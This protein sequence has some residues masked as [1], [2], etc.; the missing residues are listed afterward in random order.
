MDWDEKLKRKINLSG[1][2]LKNMHYVH[3]LYYKA[4]RRITYLQEKIQVELKIVYRI[5]HPP[6]E[7][8]EKKFGSMFGKVFKNSVLF[9]ELK[10]FDLL[11][12]FINILTD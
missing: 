9:R 2:F 6:L 10:L 7:I 4:N 8:F 11:S 12:H 3:L 1:N 5:L